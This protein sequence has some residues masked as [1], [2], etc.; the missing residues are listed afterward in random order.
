MELD[1]DNEGNVIIS[2][3]MGWTMTS[4]AGT[5]VLLRLEYATTPEERR[6]GGRVLQTVMSPAQA[7]EIAEALQ[8]HAHRILGAPPPQAKPS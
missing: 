5:A 7:L 6:T 4:V 8:R 1:T 2:P 3:L